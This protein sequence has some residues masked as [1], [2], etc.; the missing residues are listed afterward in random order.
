VLNAI[1]D[2]A[3]PI[4]NAEA[5]ASHLKQGYLVTE[6]GGPHIIFGWGNACVDDLVAAFLVS[7]QLP[8]QKKTTCDGV[9]AREFVPL[10]PLDAS[11]YVDASDPLTAL[12]TVYDQFYYMPEYYYWDQKTTTTFGCPDG[13]SWKF[14]SSDTGEIYTLRECAFSTG[15]TMSGD[16]SYNYDQGL[17]TLN[18]SVSGLATGTLLYTR[19]ADDK[20]H[21]TGNYNG[22]PIDLSK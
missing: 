20:T 12:S 2:P 13:G 10:A 22:L 1:A 15:F 11:E 6:T 21:I 17:F 4:S 9:V 8:A 19:D 7:D 14:E 16:G 5:V 3:T 18:L